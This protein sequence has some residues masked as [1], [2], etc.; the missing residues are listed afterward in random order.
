MYH[1]EALEETEEIGFTYLTYI[2]YIITKCK[3]EMLQ[4]GNVTLSSFYTS[5]AS[6]LPHV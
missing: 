2:R 6:L 3:D 5:Y 4:D 1:T